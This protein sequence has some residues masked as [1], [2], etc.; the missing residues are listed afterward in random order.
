MFKYLIVFFWI[1]GSGKNKIFGSNPPCKT[2]FVK[3]FKAQDGSI[4][5]SKF[6]PFGFTKLLNSL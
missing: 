4:S 1:S 2:T 6:N 5:K 3:F